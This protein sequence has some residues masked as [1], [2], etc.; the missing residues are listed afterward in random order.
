MYHFLQETEALRSARAVD[1]NVL[2]DSHSRQ[3][4]FL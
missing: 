4:L 1:L 2:Y 3:R